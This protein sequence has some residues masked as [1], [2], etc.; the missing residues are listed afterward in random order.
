MKLQIIAVL[1]ALASLTLAFRTSTRLHNA[2]KFQTQSDRVPALVLPSGETEYP[3]CFLNQT[4][5][6][7]GLDLPAIECSCGCYYDDGSAGNFHHNL[8][9]NQHCD[10]NTPQG[11]YGYCC[12]MFDTP[13]ESQCY[14]Y[15]L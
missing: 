3:T 6:A 2:A 8:C 15:P 5:P 10:G 11:L 14:D 4:Y 1:I 7:T 13:C 9:Q 12:L